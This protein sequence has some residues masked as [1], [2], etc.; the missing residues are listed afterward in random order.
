MIFLSSSD[1]E[2][3][4]YRI[5]QSN[6]LNQIEIRPSAIQIHIFSVL[7]AHLQVKSSCCP[8]KVTVNNSNFKLQEWNSPCF[9]GDH[10][11]PRMFL[12]LVFSWWELHKSAVIDR[13]VLLYTR[14]RPALAE[15]AHG[16]M[17]L[18]Q[19]GSMHSLATEGMWGCYAEPEILTC[20]AN[21]TEC[22]HSYIYSR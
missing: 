4:Q 14:Q 5:V 1:F 2:S 7:L 21:C 8:V 6:Y 16:S 9:T 22:F 17:V 18:Q 3:L 10:L 13:A 19:Q 20:Y 15:L 11:I 12:G